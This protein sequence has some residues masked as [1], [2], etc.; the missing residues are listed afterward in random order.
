[1]INDKELNTELQVGN[2]RDRKSGCLHAQR[3]K[4]RSDKTICPYE[5]AQTSGISA[6][7]FSIAPVGHQRF[8]TCEQAAQT[9][10]KALGS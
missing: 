7:F 6:I 1:M 3:E 5:T 9:R 8:L 4:R 2:E 10:G